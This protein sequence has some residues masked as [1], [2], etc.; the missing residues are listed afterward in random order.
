MIYCLETL[1]D[2]GDDNE[3]WERDDEIYSSNC[4][5][6]D[7]CGSRVEQRSSKKVQGDHNRIDPAT[8]MTT[9]L[10]K[11]KKLL[12]PCI[13]HDGRH[14]TSLMSRLICSRR[15]SFEED[16]DESRQT[17]LMEQLS[18]DLVCWEKTSKTVQTQ[19]WMQN[20]FSK[21]PTQEMLSSR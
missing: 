3:T 11:Q 20:D 18:R 16:S 6:L 21:H 2:D 7:T 13:L 1:P 14:D 9:V 17:I 10:K 19:I 5:D 8:Q 15:I 12:R 4:N